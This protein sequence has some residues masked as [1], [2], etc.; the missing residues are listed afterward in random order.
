MKPFAQKQDPTPLRIGLLSYRSNPHCGGQG[1]YLKNLGLAL[2]GLGHHVEVITGPPDPGIGNAIPVHHLK[3]LD[4]YNPED[5]FRLPGLDELVDPINLI[6]WLGVS[7]MGFPEPLTF[8]FRVLRFLRDTGRR[9]DIIHDNQSLSYGLWALQQ[10]IP[11]VATIHHPITV[12]RTIA[13][14]SERHFFPKLKHLRWYAFV[15]MQKRVARTLGRII[16]VSEAASRDICRDFGIGPGRISV[17]ANGIA[18]D[19]F[20]P[21]PRIA[22]DPCRVIVTTSAETPLKGLEHLLAAMA[23][24]RRHRATSR[25]T[26][27]GTPRANGRIL[28][29]VAALGLGDAVRFTG[30]IDDARFAEEYAG[31]GCCVVPSLYEGFGLPA[32]EAMACAVPVI[33]TRA[34]ALPEVVGDAGILVPP[35]DP[36]ALAVAI[37]GLMDDPA[38]ATALGHQGMA[39]VHAHFSWQAAARRTVDVYRQVIAED[40]KRRQR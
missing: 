38:K 18:T 14:K 8:G 2:A 20:R 27:V 11:V 22:R 7:T 30:R 24:V 4:L 1:V 37:I 29:M 28:K 34:G 16:T 31:A 10:R 36:Q 21:L 19:I 13:L 15:G 26:V 40:G 6:E 3:G 12:D 25:L 9:F 23:L 5:L 35:A 32:G 17:V 33:A 39:R